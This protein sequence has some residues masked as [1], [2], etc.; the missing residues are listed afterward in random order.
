[1][2][3]NMESAAADDF[4]RLVR[5]SRPAATGG[6]PPAQPERAVLVGRMAERIF[7]L[8]AAGEAVTEADLARAGFDSAEIAALFPQAMRQARAALEILTAR[9]IRRMRVPAGAAGA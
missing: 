3:C 6:T 1:M 5:E 7:D 9:G 4:E 8:A 2:L